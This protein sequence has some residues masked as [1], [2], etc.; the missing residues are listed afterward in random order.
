MANLREYLVKMGQKRAMKKV[1]TERLISVLVIRWCL[2]LVLFGAMGGGVVLGSAKLFDP[3]T[4]PLKVVSIKG[5]F[6]YLDQQK[7]ERAM[8]TEVREG[9][10]T[11]DVEA[12]HARL[13]QMPWVAK[14]AVRRVW[15]DT[16]L[17]FV[18]EQVPFAQWGT[19]GL[20]NMQGGVFQ[21]AEKDIP[22]GLLKLAGPK[23]M[24]QEMVARYRDM[25]PRFESVGLQI[26]SIKQNARQAWLIEFTDKSAIRLG[27]QQID[28][29]VARFIRVYPQLKVAGRGL[30]KQVDLRYP[31]GFVVHWELNG[32]NE[33][34]TRSVMGITKQNELG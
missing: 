5:D 18:E 3:Q 22:A 26:A 4:F 28:K 2:A 19:T 29:R 34:S 33:V 20:L 15:P 11:L 7:L 23:G 9:F 8:S 17:V 31:N 14:V 13:L 10:F 6:K 24:E 25:Q 21:P 1:K 16:L 32:L 30:P 27:S 12:V